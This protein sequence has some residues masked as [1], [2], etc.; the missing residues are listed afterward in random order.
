MICRQKKL[1]KVASPLRDPFAK[2]SRPL[3]GRPWRNLLKGDVFYLGCGSR[4]GFP[5]RIEKEVLAVEAPAPSLGVRALL[6]YLIATNLA[7]FSS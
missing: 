2:P 6:R 7:A 4:P 1:A 3:K 5:T